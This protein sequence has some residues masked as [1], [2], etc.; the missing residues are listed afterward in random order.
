[1][2]LSYCRIAVAALALSPFSALAAPSQE[3]RAREYEQVRRIALRDPKV[4][5]AYAA[6]DRRLDEKIV[7]IDPTLA[8]YVKARRHVVAQA[9]E[10]P[11]PAR[12][13]APKKPAKKAAAPAHRTTAHVVAKGDTLST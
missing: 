10:A 6:A 11:E 13:S 4:Q 8:G 7:S 12:A 1:M 9:P 3:S 2:F 5:G